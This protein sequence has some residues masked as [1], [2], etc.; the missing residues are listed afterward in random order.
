MAVFFFPGKWWE[1]IK[2]GSPFFKQTH[3]EFYIWIPTVDLRWVL[4]LAVPRLE[5]LIAPRPV[6]GMGVR[7]IYVSKDGDKSWYNGIPQFFVG[8]LT[9]NGNFQ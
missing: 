2:F 5:V 8:K 1:T 7:Q 4:L 3:L 6:I 9:I